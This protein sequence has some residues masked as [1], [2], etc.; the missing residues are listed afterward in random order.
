MFRTVV[1]LAGRRVEFADRKEVYIALA[2]AIL[3]II[4]LSGVF[5][6]IPGVFCYYEGLCAGIGIGYLYLSISMARFFEQLEEGMKLPEPSVAPP[7][8]EFV[9]DLFSELRKKGTP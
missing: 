6:S 3:G 8:Q 4:G 9:K 7:T 5:G 2:L 1:Y